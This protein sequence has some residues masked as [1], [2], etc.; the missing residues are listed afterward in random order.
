M[1]P[2]GNIYIFEYKHIN[3]VMIFR[4][5]KKIAF[6]MNYLSELMWEFCE[7]LFLWFEINSKVQLLVKRPLAKETLKKLS[8]TF[9]IQF[10]SSRHCI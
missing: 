5:K 1:S 10:C 2:N 6:S 7:D 4:E 3:I 8:F 9:S